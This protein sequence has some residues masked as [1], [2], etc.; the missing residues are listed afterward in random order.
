MDNKHDRITLGKTL[1]AIRKEKGLSAYKVSKN[2]SIS[3]AHVKVIEDGE[4]NYT[5]DTFFGYIAGVDMQI[6]FNN[7]Q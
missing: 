2:C 1:K 6:S 3:I 5:I 7:K 4:T